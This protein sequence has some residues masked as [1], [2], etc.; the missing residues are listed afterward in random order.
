MIA[1][2]APAI[3]PTIGGYLTDY[4]GWP[5][6]FYVNL[7][8]GAVMLVALWFTLPKSE[9]QP[10]LLRQGDWLGIA[11]MALSLHLT[12]AG[13][14]Y[15]GSMQARPGFIVLAVASAAAIALASRPR[16]RGQ[17]ALPREADPP[18]AHR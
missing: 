9:P 4:Y 7:A 2:F 16:P 14:G 3:G 13:R 18:G 10:A 17:A 11:L 15:A 12:G 5:W 1:T 8:P 6:C